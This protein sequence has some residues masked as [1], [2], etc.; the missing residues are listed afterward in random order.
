MA[1]LSSAASTAAVPIL[2]TATP[3]ARLAICAAFSMGAPAERERERGH[4]R[5][6]RARHVIDL[7]DLGRQMD[8]KAG[9]F[10]VTSTVIPRAPRVITTAE[11]PV[12]A[13][14]ARPARAAPS[15]FSQSM[16]VA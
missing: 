7:P 14:M 11:H 10:G 13:A 5:I 4:D 12:I 9:P 15:S 8:D 16:P 1:R 6:S 2:P 3:A